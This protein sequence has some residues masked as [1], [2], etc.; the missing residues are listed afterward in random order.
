[1]AVQDPADLPQLRFKRAIRWPTGRPPRDEPECGFDGR[2]CGQDDHY[3]WWSTALL[4]TFATMILFFGI[5]AIVT[6]RL[7]DGRE[8]TLSCLLLVS[9]FIFFSMLDK[10]KFCII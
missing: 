3:S 2:K 9:S 6:Y 1:M 4:L 8:G 5:A 10:I 7:V